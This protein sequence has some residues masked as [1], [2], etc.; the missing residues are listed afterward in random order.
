[1]SQQI[2]KN[3]L[4]LPKAEWTD[5]EWADAQQMLNEVDADTWQ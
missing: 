4:S 3:Y 2:R 1:M 5:A